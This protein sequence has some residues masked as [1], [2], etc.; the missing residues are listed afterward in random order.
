MVPPEP[1]SNDSIVLVITVTYWIVVV[2]DK[3]LFSNML[4]ER[5]FENAT[6]GARILA[7]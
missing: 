2:A 7:V 6:E 4:D 3:R 5:S 1:T